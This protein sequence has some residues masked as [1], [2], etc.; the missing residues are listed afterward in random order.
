[1]IDSTSDSKEFSFDGIYIGYIINWFGDNF[2]IFANMRNQDS[3]IV[4]DTHI[5][6]QP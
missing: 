6:L 4:F 2:L 5:L 3:Y 1:M